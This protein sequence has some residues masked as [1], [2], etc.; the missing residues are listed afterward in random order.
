MFILRFLKYIDIIL[1]LYLNKNFN[2]YKIKVTSSRKLTNYL[3][4]VKKIKH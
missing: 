4:I 2:I 3:N 1:M